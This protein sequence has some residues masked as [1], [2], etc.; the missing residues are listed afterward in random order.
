MAKTADIWMAQKSGFR[1]TAKQMT[2]PHRNQCIADSTL[3]EN[4]GLP[5]SSMGR[6]RTY[7][8]SLLCFSISPLSGWSYV[9]FADLP[10][11]LLDEEDENR[12]FL[13]RGDPYYFSHV[14]NHQLAFVTGRHIPQRG[15]SLHGPFRIL[16]LMDCFPP[17]IVSP[18]HL[19]IL[20]TKSKCILRHVVCPIAH[21][22]RRRPNT[23]NDEKI[24]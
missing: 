10:T 6:L 20:F 4:I 17:S 8:L 14:I 5:R 15:R 7:E 23:S 2:R 9:E 18:I 13:S 22:V 11:S 1:R 19:S 12:P 24:R 21:H 3:F 16:I